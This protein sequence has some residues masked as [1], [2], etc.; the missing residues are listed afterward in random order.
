MTNKHK[1]GRGL[2]AETPYERLSFTMP[3]HLKAYLD[4]QA[5][6]SGVSRSEMLARIL[7]DHQAQK[8]Q[9]KPHKS[10]DNQ[11]VVEASPTSA[12]LSTA[13]TAPN[14]PHHQ[15]VEGLR[16]VSVK[17]PRHIRGQ[18]RWSKERYQQAEERLAQGKTLSRIPGKADWVT[19]KGDVISWR[20][21]EALIKSGIVK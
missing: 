9:P 11:K 13:L 14:Q 21:I 18:L 15:D 20:T 8:Q 16:V 2:K 4:A 19:E 12:D 7:E 10:L 1:G 3:P 6:G 17:I 5:E